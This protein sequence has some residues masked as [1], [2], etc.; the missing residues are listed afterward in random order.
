MIQKRSMDELGRVTPDKFRELDKFP[1]I[2]VLDNIRS[3]MNVGSVFRTADAFR[4]EKIMLCGIT[5]CPPN[6]EIHKTAL[7]ATESVDWQYFE[8]TAEAVKALRNEN[9]RVFALEQTN[10]SISLHSFTPEQNEKYA[11]IFGNEIK[12]VQENVLSLCHGCIEIPQFGTKHSFNISV[13]AGIT[14]WD[15]FSKMK[16]FESFRPLP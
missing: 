10:Q 15:F 1:I 7:G 11:L 3:M 14:L 2:L 16:Q 8:E 4:I 13:T 5:A 9:Y 6:K 12:G